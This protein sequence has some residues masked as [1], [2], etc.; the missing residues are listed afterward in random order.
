MHVQSQ[1]L[2]RLG[3][4]KVV[5]CLL[6]AMPAASVGA[7]PEA[8]AR[9]ALIFGATAVFVPKSAVGVHPHEGTD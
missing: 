3:H 2:P 9:A 1:G 8:G 7:A 6:W 5:D 4:K